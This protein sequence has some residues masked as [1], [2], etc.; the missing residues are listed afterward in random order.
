MPN[1]L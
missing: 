1:Q